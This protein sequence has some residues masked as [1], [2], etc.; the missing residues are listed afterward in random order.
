MEKEF[1]GSDDSE[2]LLK[3]SEMG[4]FGW[5]FQPEIWAAQA[6]WVSYT[7]VLSRTV[8]KPRLLANFSKPEK[9]L[10]CCWK[11]KIVQ[12]SLTWVNLSW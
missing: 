12:Y 7:K 3:A 8:Q 6:L 1:P 5:I 4:M 9:D 2:M 11:K 10:F